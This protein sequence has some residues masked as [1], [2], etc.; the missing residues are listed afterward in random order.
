MTET[1]DA[2]DHLP[3]V[4]FL[5]DDDAYVEKLPPRQA[6]R[7]GSQKGLM[8]RQVAGKEF[9]D[10]YLSHARPN[11]VVAL[12]RNRASRASLERAWKEH[13]GAQGRPLEVVPVSSFHARFFPSSPASVIHFPNPPDVHYAWARMHAGPA[14]FALSGLTHTICSPGVARFLCDAVTAPFEPFDTLICISRAAVEVVKAVTGTYA[15]YLRDRQGGD[16]RL[17][18]RLEHIPLGVNPDRYRPATPPERA[19]ARH[20][21]EIE[22]DEVVALFLGRL[23]FHAKVHPFPIY[24]GLARAARAT[25]QKVHLVLAGWASTPQILKA[26]V[27][28]ARVFAP[29]I[30]VSIVDGSRPDVRSSVWHAADI[31]TSLTD[32][33][34]ETLSQA[35]LEGMACGLPVVVTNWDGC[36]DQVVDGESGLLV[37]AYMVQGATR[38]LTSRLLLGETT[39]DHFLG[40]CNQAVAVDVRAAGD[41]FA[42]LIADPVL[43]QGMGA[44]GR[45]RILERF[46]WAAVVAAYERLWQEQEAERQEVVAGPGGKAEDSLGPA[47]YPS[48]ERSF[49]S[50]PTALLTGTEQVVANENGGER[51]DWLLR[52]PLTSYAAPRRTTQAPV[53]REVL[54]DATTPAVVTRLDRVF[55]KHQLGHAVGRATLAWMLKYGLLH[56]VQ[57]GE[58]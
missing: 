7:S 19:A 42:R 16:P 37:P 17:R 5:Y 55:E 15:D 22:E 50:Y 34:Q 40:E 48:V 21:L 41:A 36:K 24:D 20:K 46:T 43:R 13:P 18:L 8:G 38:D 49:A 35:V 23:S 32:N 31:F 58:G 30:R 44:A 10:A 12:V 9:L 45:Q 51:L 33:I 1:E 47:C 4:A 6:P 14:A 27:E 2:D 26:F 29:N 57:N 28:G 25:G 11:R 54:G 53:L 56:V 52:L 39:Y 3:P